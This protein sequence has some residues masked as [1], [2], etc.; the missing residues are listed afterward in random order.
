LGF[1]K[2]E[3]IWDGQ[4]VRLGSYLWSSDRA[5]ITG[6]CKL[7]EDNSTCCINDR[8]SWWGWWWIYFTYPNSIKLEIYSYITYHALNFLPSLAPRRRCLGQ[9]WGYNF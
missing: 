2:K 3:I 4:W 9:T 8:D 6:Q 7:S 5:Y 1:G